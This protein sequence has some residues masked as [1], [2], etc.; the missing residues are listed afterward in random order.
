MRNLANIFFCIYLLEENFARKR[1]QNLFICVNWVALEL[2]VKISNV[3]ALLLFSAI[4]Q[5]LTKICCWRILK[6]ITSF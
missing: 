5:F 4:C 3:M 6:L 1:I 2:F